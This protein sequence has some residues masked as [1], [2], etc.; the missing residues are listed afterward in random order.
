MKRVL[1]LGTDA[2][3]RE[4][5]ASVLSDADIRVCGAGR[6]A[7]VDD[8]CRR[9]MFDLVVMLGAVPFFDG[10]D[11]VSRLRPHG[12]KRPEI[13]VI[14]WQQSEQ[15]VM[16]LLECGVNQY[17]TFPVNMRRFCRKVHDSILSR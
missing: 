3:M 8:E 1:I 5:V 11:V 16:S 7:D 10:S 13:F 9:G 15:T 6:L 2:P 14:S 12:I 4:M 17:M